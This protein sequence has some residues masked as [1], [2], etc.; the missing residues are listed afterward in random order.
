M[1]SALRAVRTLRR[2]WMLTAIS[3][4]SL[5]IAMALGIVALSV[6]NTFLLL[7]PAAPQADRLV[8]VY[9][10]G[11]GEPIE[12][13][14]YLDYDYYRRNNHVF[15]DIAAA[16]DS[17]AVSVDFDAGGREVKIVS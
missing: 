7:P 15:T 10:H 3:G 2:H 5:S 11:P 12:Q 17:I 16:P 13:I 9:H 8:M 4:F 6:S 1:R 14:S